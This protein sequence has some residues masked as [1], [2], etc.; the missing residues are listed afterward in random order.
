MCSSPLCSVGEKEL[1]HRWGPA[2]HR[3]ALRELQNLFSLCAS[4]PQLWL[5]G[6]AEME[7]RNA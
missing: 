3:Q 6:D 4:I 1:R 5:R 2:A 7:V